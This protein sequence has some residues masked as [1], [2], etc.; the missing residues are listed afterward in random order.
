MTL[1]VATFILCWAPYNL[2]IILE[3]LW[4][5]SVP[6]SVASFT[7]Y[8]LWLNSVIN[9]GLYAATNPLFRKQLKKMFSFC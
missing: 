2:V 8:L 7:E 6:K 9:P 4:E 3:L 5:N 1:L